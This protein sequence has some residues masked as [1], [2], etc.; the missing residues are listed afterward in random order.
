[1]AYFIHLKQDKTLDAFFYLMPFSKQKGPLL[2]IIWAKAQQN[3]LFTQQRLRSA[4]TSIKSDQ[5]LHN[6]F[7]G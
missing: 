7:L 3:D 5:S 1:M 6:A 2:Q 4:W